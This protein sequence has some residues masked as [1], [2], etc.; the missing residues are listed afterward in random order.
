VWRWERGGSPRGARPGGSVSGLLLL[1]AAVCAGMRGYAR[2]SSALLCARVGCGAL[3]CTAVLLW[4]ALG[5][6]W[7]IY[8]LL[9]A[10]VCTGIDS[11]HG[12]ARVSSALLCARVGC[13]A[14]V[15]TAAQWYAL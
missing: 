4:C 13:G 3:V 12:Y 1:R 10:A 6:R 11:M 8:L 14:L 5:A 2:V 9:R 15:C 7:G